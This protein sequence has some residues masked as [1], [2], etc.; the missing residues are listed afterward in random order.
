MG[1]ERGRNINT[2]RFRTVRLG[3]KEQQRSTEWQSGQGWCERRNR[4]AVTAKSRGEQKDT[5]RERGK[6]EI[7]KQ[8]D[9]GE[10][11]LVKKEE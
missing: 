5:E 11:V 7:D 9:R 3:E 1:E 2:W 4:R 8:N 6:K 10:R